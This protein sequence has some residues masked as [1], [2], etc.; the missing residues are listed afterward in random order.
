MKCGGIGWGLAVIPERAE[1]AN[2]ESIAASRS[3]SARNAASQTVVMDSGLGALRQSGMTTV[4][5]A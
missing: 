3:E 4:N 5:A 1:G 2:P